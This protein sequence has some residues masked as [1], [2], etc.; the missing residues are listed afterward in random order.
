MLAAED[1]AVGEV[2]R[3]GGQVSRREASWDAPSEL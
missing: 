3:D 2:E 1:G